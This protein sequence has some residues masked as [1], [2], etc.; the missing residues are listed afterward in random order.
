[1]GEMASSFLRRRENVQQI[2]TAITTQ[3]SQNGNAS[4]QMMLATWEG[5][6]GWMIGGWVRVCVWLG[7]SRVVI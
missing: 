6:V 1:M 7:W 3:M 2:F 5:A 4:H